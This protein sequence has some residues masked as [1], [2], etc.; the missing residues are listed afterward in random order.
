MKDLL[1]LY[2]F[3]SVHNSDDETA[4]ADWICK[5]LDEHGVKDY[6]RDVNTIYRF[7]SGTD[8]IVLSAHLDQVKTNGKAVHFYM[9][10]DD[11]IIAYNKNWERTS[12]GADDKNG[13]WLIL[14]AIEAG[15]DTSFIISEGEEAGLIGINQLSYQGVLADKLDPEVNCCIVL[16]R[17]GDGDVLYQGGGTT[18]CNTLAD[19]LINFLRDPLLVRTTG[20][21]SD[22]CEISQF[23]ESVNMSVAYF[24]PH[25]ANEYTDWARLEEIKNNVL[26]ILNNFVHYPCLP[27][28][29][30]RKSYYQ[31]AQKNKTIYDKEYWRDNQGRYYDDWY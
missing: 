1:K 30:S 15:L 17:K 10:P 23:C 27:D 14:K 6:T 22:T 13:V 26:D 12:L 8:G 31:T 11:Y 21:V 3:E 2:S 20:S 18:F 16:D 29:Y 19:N 25:T 4:I 28:T 5:W 24:N 7:S 9:T